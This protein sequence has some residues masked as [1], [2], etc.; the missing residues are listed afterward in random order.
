MSFAELFRYTR[1]M[2]QE[3]NVQKKSGWLT[4]RIL[5]ED[6]INVPTE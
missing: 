4:L 2:V 1:T 5:V 3:Y 6:F